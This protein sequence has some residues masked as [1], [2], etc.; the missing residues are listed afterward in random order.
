M[1]INY[2]VSPN[3][4][5]LETNFDIRFLKKFESIF[6]LG[7][8]YI[9]S[10][11][12]LE[13][14]YSGEK[15]N[16]FIAGTFNKFAEN[17]VAE[18][19][20][21]PDVFGMEIKIDGRELNL[22]EGK[23][24]DYR[25]TLD[26]KKGEIIRS[27]TW[28]T[29][30]DKRLFFE[31]RRF[32]SSRNKHLVAQ[33]ILVKLLEG[34]K[35]QLEICCGINGQLTN[36]GTQHLLEGKK[37]FIDKKY[38]Y[39][40]SRTSNSLIDIGIL[41]NPKQ[42]SQK[43]FDSKVQLGR[44]KIT[45][46]CE[47]ELLAEQEYCLEIESIYCT[48][49]DID[50]KRNL[51]IEQQSEYWIRQISDKKYEELLQES[52]EYRYSH[53]WDKTDIWVK[54]KNFM[55]QLGIWF[56][57]HHLHAMTPFHDNRMNIGA[58][59][60][61]GEGYKGH[62]FWDTEIFLL[63]YFIYHY[64]EQAKKLLEYRIL[65]LPEAKKKAFE[66]GYEGAMFPW[67]SAWIEDGE[68]T[69][70]FWGTDIVTGE[71]IE[72]LVGSLE[73]HISSDIVY[74]LMKY[75][76]TTDDTKFLDEKGYRLLLEVTLFWLSRMEWNESE[77]RFEINQVIGPDEY[78]EAVDNN[79]FTNYMA[80]WVLSTAAEQIERIQS[81]IVIYNEWNGKFDLEKIYKEIKQKLP[82]LYLP[83]MNEN[84]I[85]PQ[86]TS[87]L[88]KKIIDLSKYKNAQVVGTIFDDYN[89]NQINEIQVSKQ[90][91]LMMVFFLLDE[92]FTNEEKKKNWDY[93]EDKTLH[94][95]SLS[96][97]VYSILATDIG[98]IEYAYKLFQ[99]AYLIDMGE[100]MFSS[101]D[102]IHAASFGGVWQCIAFGFAGIKVKKDCIQINPKLPKE[103]E[104]LRFN[105]LYQKQKISLKITKNEL[106]LIN[107]SGEKEFLLEINEE[108]YKVRN[109]FKI[110]LG[111]KQ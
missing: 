36:S 29:N 38:L 95:S 93:Y 82:L 70:R 44:R 103:W 4:L 2:Q 20:N 11:G 107:K 98:K 33:K 79:A 50:R 14:S 27:F 91:D 34:K 87:Y 28:I 23:V 64:P 80:A 86:D 47:G 78:K 30:K 108:L 63:P 49:R 42:T 35:A 96:L 40:E 104:E 59:G 84:G 1:N 54:S 5:I 100:N 71:P 6:A 102:G 8:G 92:L 48:S 24:I 76:E 111:D 7:N 26:I 56:A 39:M 77:K 21:L 57:E 22:S 106:E 83:T 58:K 46:K 3:P 43:K 12:S 61:S 55:D 72:L 85:I 81:K 62:T 88:Q 110:K 18:L 67:E 105:F 19:P 13:E 37:R 89:L 32:I 15:R 10:R 69:P 65:S 75:V 101:D 68:N 31:F 25:R 45:Q 52:V 109:H 53:I 94:D 60:L 9:G 90:A 99:R 41:M 97:A 17:E 66:H 51:S 16:T 73:Q 74:G